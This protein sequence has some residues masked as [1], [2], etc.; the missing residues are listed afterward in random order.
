MR[1]E[2]AERLQLEK[3][4][5]LLN[6]DATVTKKEEHMLQEVI[7]LEEKTNLILD[8]GA[9][10]LQKLFRGCRDRTIVRTLKKKMKKGK[11]GK[12]KGKSSKKK[13]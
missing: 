11:N 13:K 4:L 10:Q 12:R 5:E 3:Q 9:R 6:C 7:L 8:N 2:A 1:T